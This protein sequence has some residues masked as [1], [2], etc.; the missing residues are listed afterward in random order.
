MTDAL[1]KIGPPAVPYI[2]PYLESEDTK[3]EKWIF[4]RL[5]VFDSLTRIGLRYH[6]DLGG[7]LDHIIIPK[8][9]EIAADEDNERYER[10]SVIYAQEALDLL[11]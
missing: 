10:S 8:F 7:V 4:I 9:E 2:L 11:Q 6:D 3:G 1:V 5:G